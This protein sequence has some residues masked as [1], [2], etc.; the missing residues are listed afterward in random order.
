MNEIWKERS[1]TYQEPIKN[2]SRTKVV[3]IDGIPSRAF[4]QG[5]ETPKKELI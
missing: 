4:K 2:L 1:R 3:V 5:I